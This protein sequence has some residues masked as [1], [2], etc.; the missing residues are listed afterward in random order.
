[1][2]PLFLDNNLI[3]H[4]FPSPC[5]SSPQTGPAEVTLTPPE[6]KTVRKRMEGEPASTSLFHVSTYHYLPRF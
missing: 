2:Q 1:M 5:K 3:Q 6:K 4:Y